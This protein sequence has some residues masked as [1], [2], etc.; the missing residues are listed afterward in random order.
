MIISFIQGAVIF[1][2]NAHE[3]VGDVCYHN[4]LYNVNV[5][6]SNIKYLAD[7]LRSH[8]VESAY[9]AG[10]NGQR[11]DL[12]LR[13]NQTLT[14]FYALTNNTCYAL[15][16]NQRPVDL[17]SANNNFNPYVP[18]DLNSGN[19][20]CN[21]TIAVHPRPQPVECLPIRISIARPCVLKPAPDINPCAPSKAKSKSS[22]AASSSSSCI[23]VPSTSEKPCNLILEEYFTDSSCSSDT[24]SYSSDCLPKVCFRETSCSESSSSRYCDQSSETRCRKRYRCRPVRKRCP[25]PIQYECSTVS[26]YRSPESSSTCSSEWNRNRRKRYKCKPVREKC[27]RPVTYKCSPAS[28]STKPSSCSEQTRRLRCHTVKP[29]KPNYDNH[30]FRKDS[31]KYDNKK[32]SENI[33]DFL[34]SKNCNGEKENAVISRDVKKALFK[35]FQTVSKNPE[36]A[37]R[38]SETLSK[39]R[40]NLRSA[41]GVQEAI[42]K[43]I[44]HQK[45][46]LHPD[47]LDDQPLTT[48]EG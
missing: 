27:F 6:A 37:K 38:L 42:S 11:S 20:N 39:T 8:C 7:L 31:P 4:G 45:K 28:S 25:R 19:N 10:W 32:I 36:A 48:V 3:N 24:R 35:V 12:V 1:R 21:N 41:D 14:P 15:C 18:C 29:K 5:N 17:C 40:N 16:S 13:P 30:R 26:S 46:R 34:K 9:V 43:G 33:V 2:K 44:M 47:M 22:S 23:T